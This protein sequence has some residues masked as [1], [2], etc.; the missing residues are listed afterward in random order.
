[1]IP[2]TGIHFRIKFDWK[3]ACDLEFKKTDKMLHYTENKLVNDL[4]TGTEL[5]WN[6]GVELVGECVADSEYQRTRGKVNGGFYR[7]TEVEMERKRNS[8]DEKEKR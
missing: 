3:L 7:K 5:A 2:Q 8:N 1:M 4:T 6:I